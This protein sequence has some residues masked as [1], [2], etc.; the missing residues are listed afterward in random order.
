VRGACAATGAAQNCVEDGMFRWI[1]IK[2]VDARKNALERACGVSL[3]SLALLTIHGFDRA[4][5]C[6]ARSSI[7]PADED[8]TAV[9][10]TVDTIGTA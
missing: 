1:L 7:F 10:K 2:H 4:L 6:D 9:D 8:N 3:H 5:K